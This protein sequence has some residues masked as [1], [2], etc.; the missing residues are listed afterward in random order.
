[1]ITKVQTGEY[2][3]ALTHRRTRI[4]FLDEKTYAWVTTEDIGDI[5]V[6]SHKKHRIDV[7]LSSGHYCM[8]QVENEP[9]LTDVWHLELQ[10]GQTMWQGYLLPT[11]L[12]D[13]YHPRRRIIPTYQIISGNA[14]YRSNYILHRR[15][16]LVPLF[17]IPAIPH[18]PGE[19][20]RSV[21]HHLTGSNDWERFKPRGG[22]P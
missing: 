16:S 20:I 21:V 8:Y 1:M 22:V 5:L 9:N 19:G 14:E 10:Y 15:R 2:R 18:L 7:M 17:P 3:F 11:G 6:S 13:K 4:L 12:P